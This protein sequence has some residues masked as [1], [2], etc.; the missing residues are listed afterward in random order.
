MHAKEA[1]RHPHDGGLVQVGGDAA[2]E[3]QGVCQL[4]EDLG[5]LAPA[6]PRGVAGTHLPQLRVRPEERD[7][8]RA[9]IYNTDTKYSTNKESKSSLKAPFTRA[10]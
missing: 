8:S 1:E 3:G 5:L 10:S 4:V 7:S 6:R 9:A 2:G